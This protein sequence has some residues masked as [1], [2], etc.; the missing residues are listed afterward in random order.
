MGGLD[1]QRRVV[2]HHA[3]RRV[4]RLTERGADDAIVGHGGV[5]PVLDEQMLLHAVD[6]DLQRAVGGRVAD[7]DRCRQRA[8]GADAQFFDRAQCGACRT[9]DVVG[10]RLQAVELFDDGERDHDVEPGEC[11]EARWIA[12]QHRSVEHN[13]CAHR[14]S[15]GRSLSTS[16]ARAC[17][18]TA[19][20]FVRRDC[21][22][23]LGDASVVPQR[24]SC[25]ADF[26]ADGGCTAN[27]RICA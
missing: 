16:T 15:C 12:D 14:L 8:A 2:R 13:S 1:A 20:P 26:A 24:P 9:T 7:G 3:S 23:V 25:S 11:I 17:R 19:L 5:E 27:A 18:S 4:L 21:R 22:R 10:S 6:L